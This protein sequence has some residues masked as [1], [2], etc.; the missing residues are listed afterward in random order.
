MTPADNL[1]SAL[2]LLRLSIA[3]VFLSAGYSCT[4][5]KGAFARIKHETECFFP[6]LPAGGAKE[7]MGGIAAMIGMAMIYGGGISLLLGIEPRLGGLDVA[8]FSLLGLRVHHVSRSIALRAA[9]AGD[10]MGIKAVSGLKASAMKNWVVVAAGLT[11]FLVG[12]GKY[13]L[14]IDHTGKYLGW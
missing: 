6:F 12:G 11:F 3:A 9:M 5:T 8:L 14:G 10:E 7:R 2:L 13:G 4:V 1:D